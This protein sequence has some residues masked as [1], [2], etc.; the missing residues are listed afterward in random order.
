[1]SLSSFNNTT[2]LSFSSSSSSTASLG[3]RSNFTMQANSTVLVSPL[4][5]IRERIR[6]ALENV[7]ISMSPYDTAWVAMV[8]S[9]NSPHSPRFPEC[10]QWLLDNQLDNGSWGAIDPHPLLVKDAL[11][12]TLACVLA[13]KQWGIGQEH[14]GRGLEYLKSNFAS[15]YDDKQYTPIGFDILFPGLIEYAGHLDLNLPLR[16]ADK[17]DMLHRRYSELN[18][19]SESN[20]EGGNSYL[21]YLSEGVGKLQ[22]WEMVMKHQRKNGSLFNSPSATAA[23]LIHLQNSDCHHYLRTVLDKFGNAVPAIYPFDISA[24]LSIVTALERLGMDRHFKKE[25][26]YVLDETYRRWLQGEEEIFLDAATCAMAFHALRVNGY[27]VSS[28]SLSQFSEEDGFVSS[29]EGYLKDIGSVLELYRASQLTIYPDE[30]VLMKQNS[31]TSN[32]LRQELSNGLGN[33]AHRIEIHN[34][35]LGKEVGDALKFPYHANLDRLAHRRSME[36]YKADNIRILKTS[37]RLNIRNEDLLTLA[38]EDFNVCQSTYQ[39]ELEHLGRW[40]VENKLD[41]LKFARQKLAYCYFSAAASIFPPELSNAR[42][43]WAKNGVLT[44]VVDDFF[45][46]GG[47]TEELLNLIQLMEKW[48]VNVSVDSCSEHVEIIFSALHS[49]ICEIAENALIRQGRDVTKQVVKIWLDLLKSMLQEAEWTK[50][51]TVPTLKEYME[52]AY[53]SFA[54]GPIVLPAVFLV[55]PKVSDEVVNSPEFLKL[56]QHMSTCGRLLNDYQGYKRESAQGKLNAVSLHMIHGGS[57]ITEADVVKKLKS[58]IDSRRR[59]MLRLVLRE[60]G[61]TCPRACKDLFWKMIR[62][63]HLFY[64]K[65]D[66]FTAEDMMKTVKAL[67]NEPVGLN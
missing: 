14:M 5:G 32:F 41:K 59:E 31:W 52:N 23:A 12:S 20:L 19:I 40:V 66:G 28:D 43:S 13:L 53:V 30:T 17:I 16:S 7:E 48:D 63:L 67:F 49:T 50:N 55:G 22:D 60:N 46:V 42:T 10:L 29:L 58:D 44:T 64:M 38:M 9:E 33:A 21:A 11:S 62:V 4:E 39:K 56:Y 34:K 65:D 37:Y 51:K 36:H 26:K 45:D 27:D 57:G 6:K 61:S 54:L 8:P 25:I 24:R 2:T 3:G 1:M 35:R 47:T 18:R 15:V